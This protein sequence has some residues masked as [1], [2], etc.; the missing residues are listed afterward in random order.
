MTP[1][2]VNATPKC[3]YCNGHLVPVG[4]ARSNGK[5]HADWNTRKLHKKCWKEMQENER[6]GVPNYNW[7][8]ICNEYLL[9]PYLIKD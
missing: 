6:S 8:E 1:K 3:E 7:I 9:S 2:M 4:S 5:D